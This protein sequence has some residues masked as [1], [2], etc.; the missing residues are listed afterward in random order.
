MATIRKRGTHQW[1]AIVRRKGFPRYSSTFKTKGEATKWADRIE[2]SILND[3]FKGILKA[4]YTSLEE[5]MERY[6]RDVIPLKKCVA[7]EQSRY[8][9]VTR[10]LE[11]LKILKKPIGKVTPE[12]IMAYIEYREGSV[13]GRT[14]NIELALVSHVFT[15]ARKKYR[16]KV[17]NP[18]SDIEKPKEAKGRNRRCTRKEE[19]MLINVAKEHGP[20]LEM[21]IIIPFA[22]E[23]LFSVQ[24]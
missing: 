12:D 24:N 16:I 18:V 21:P 13:S 15:K 22:I 20:Y 19:Q 9:L 8:K 10:H 5:V 17:D 6:L 3:T 4:D 2:E 11:H 23:M 1:E 14:I 7:S